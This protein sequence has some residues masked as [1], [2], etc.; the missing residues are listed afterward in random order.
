MN[1]VIKILLIIGMILIPS[2]LL[3]ERFFPLFR[4]SGESMYPT[5]QSGELFL[6][7]RIS[8]RGIKKLK[9]GDVICYKA[10]VGNSPVIKRIADIYS[11]DFNDGENVI[12][13]DCRGDNS[14][15]SFDSRNY[16]VISE[17][18]VI[19]RLPKK[20][21]RPNLSPYVE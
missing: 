7:R 21:Q 6:C 3:V 10:P 9:V 11:F 17:F 4:I 8:R 15:H 14:R 1:P 19:C 13:F 16:G 2:I 5:Y 18:S 12:Y 20:Y